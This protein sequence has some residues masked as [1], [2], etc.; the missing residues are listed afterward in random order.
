M[1]YLLPKAAVANPCRPPFRPNPAGELFAFSQIVLQIP[2]GMID[3]P[4][5]LRPHR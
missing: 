1:T 3:L 4:A 2:V 5:G